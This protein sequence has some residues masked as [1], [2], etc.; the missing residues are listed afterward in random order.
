MR[1]GVVGYETGAQHFHSPFIAAA[2][3]H[4][5]AG[6]VALVPD[7]LARVD[8]PDAPILPGLAILIASGTCDAIT[9]TT[10]PKT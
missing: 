9:I 2:R 1:I 4:V 3:G 10:L 5:L 8:C 7:T 6:I